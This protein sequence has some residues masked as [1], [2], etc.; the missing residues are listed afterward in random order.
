MSDKLSAYLRALINSGRHGGRTI[1]TDENTVVVYDCGQWFH[2]HTATL[3]EH[4]PHAEVSIAPSDSS[5]SGF[6]VIVKVR[7]ESP[8]LFWLS[9]VVCC[10]AALLLTARHMLRSE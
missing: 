9:A 5:L 1:R 6:I 10:V 3:Y 2:A 7:H 8:A 4:F